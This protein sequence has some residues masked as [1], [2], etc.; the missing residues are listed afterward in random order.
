M[1]NRCQRT[2]RDTCPFVAVEIALVLM[3]MPDRQQLQAR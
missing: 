2:V 1:Y 3:C